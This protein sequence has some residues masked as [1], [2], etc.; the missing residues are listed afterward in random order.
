LFVHG[1]EL[2]L[3]YSDLPIWLMMCVCVCVWAHTHTLQNSG[4]CKQAK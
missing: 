3:C 1:G 2:K 4:T